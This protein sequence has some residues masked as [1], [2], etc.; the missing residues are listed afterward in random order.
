MWSV[1]THFNSTRL[2]L[3]YS[4]ELNLE[5]NQLTFCM[6]VP[7]SPHVLP[8]KP[9]VLPTGLLISMSDSLLC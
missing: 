9:Y 5:V 2:L 7:H 8:R 1:H 6:L 4:P 3:R